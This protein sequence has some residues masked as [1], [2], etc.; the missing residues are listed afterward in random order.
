MCQ[1]RHGSYLAKTVLT[2]LVCSS[3]VPRFP[4]ASALP[5]ACAMD[6]GVV[7]NED[8][9][10]RRQA[11][12]EQVV[13]TTT[14][15]KVRPA[16]KVTVGVLLH[17]FHAASAVVGPTP[18][19]PDLVADSD[20]DVE[21]DLNKGASAMSAPLSVVVTE[22][23]KVS[24]PPPVP[25]AANKPRLTTDTSSWADKH[26]PSSVLQAILNPMRARQEVT[27][28]WQ[29]RMGGTPSPKVLVLV[30][31]SGSGK[32]TF[33][34]C[35]AAQDGV[36]LQQAEDVDSPEKLEAAIDQQVMAKPAG[37]DKRRRA[38]L[39][40]GVDGLC[41]A[42]DSS[43]ST[44]K[45]RKVSSM[46]TVLDVVA[47]ASFSMAPVIFTLHDFDTP[48]LRRLKTSSLVQ[49][50]YVNRVELSQAQPI[51][52][53]VWAA[54]RVR[55]PHGDVDAESKLAERVLRSAR[56]SF[57]GDLRQS[58]MQMQSQVLGCGGRDSDAS[59]S[60]ATEQLLNP[61]KHPTTNVDNLYRLATYHENTVKFLRENCYQSLGCDTAADVAEA[62]CD[63]ALARVWVGGAPPSSVQSEAFTSSAL[64]S[65]RDARRGVPAKSGVSQYSLAQCSSVTQRAQR[66]DRAE[67]FRRVKSKN[68][69]LAMLGST[70]LVEY[71]GVVKMYATAAQLQR[72]SASASSCIVSRRGVD[73]AHDAA[74]RHLLCPGDFEDP[75][76]SSLGVTKPDIDQ[77]DLFFQTEYR[78]SSGA[79]RS[80]VTTVKK[81]SLECRE[82]YFY[83]E[84]SSGLMEVSNKFRKGVLP[85]EAVG[86]DASM[87]LSMPGLDDEIDPGVTA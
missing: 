32:S 63:L 54:E 20:S 84:N 61:A 79:G 66:E 40:T 27:V 33:I 8:R 26:A 3:P 81:S 43:E 34:K 45:R 13:K 6:P 64:L 78:S 29:S 68:L 48:D 2:A 51:F 24:V 28:W 41:I 74:S 30:G 82:A 83:Y 76:Y 47:K 87:S 39:F 46:A 44:Y 12:V 19:A 16:E 67:L 5:C 70:A 36:V 75:W 23:Q 55:D 22:A 35:L 31:P 53:R 73:V 1:A 86:P 4:Q 52:S 62:F 69:Q 56:D 37:A 7:S 57:L 77:F 85:D 9:R 50:V 17:G 18:A 38:W 58:L 60:N 65:I 14:P 25:A 80:A 42:P 11:R 49:V 15:F 59:V 72:A 71:L 10:K 21:V